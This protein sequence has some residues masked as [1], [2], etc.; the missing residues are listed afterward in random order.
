MK[1]EMLGLLI[2]TLLIATTVLPVA[3]TYKNN[4]PIFPKNKSL[5]LAIG[6]INLR[7]DELGG[8][9]HIE[10]QSGFAL[11]F[12]EGK[13]VYVRYDNQNIS[14]YE[15][16]IIFSIIIFSRLALMIIQT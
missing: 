9:Y 11:G 14:I 3:A 2:C 5:F 15:N 1:R 8:F 12:I 7:E 10:V 16:N 13:Y 6:N 4:T